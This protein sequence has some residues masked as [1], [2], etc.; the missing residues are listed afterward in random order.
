MEDSKRQKT[1]GE[2]EKPKTLPVVGDT[3][4]FDGTNI[5]ILAVLDDTVLVDF[6]EEPGEIPLDDFQGH[7]PRKVT[8]RDEIQHS[9]DLL[10]S[11]IKK[12]KE[13]DPLPHLKELKNKAIKIYPAHELLCAIIEMEEEKDKGKLDTLLIKA[14]TKHF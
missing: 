10:R 13:F 14:I 12:R 4:N 6:G 9:M 7:K 3:Y 8:K 2:E 1:E 11:L 5:M